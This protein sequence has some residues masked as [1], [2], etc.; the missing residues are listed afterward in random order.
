MTQRGFQCNTVTPTLSSHFPQLP[1]AHCQQLSQASKRRVHHNGQA[2]GRPCQEPLTRIQT[3]RGVEEVV[4]HVVTLVVWR[5]IKLSLQITVVK[6]DSIMHLVRSN[7]HYT[8]ICTVTLTY[9]W[10]MSN[11]NDLISPPFFSRLCNL[12][13]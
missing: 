5:V 10:S 11:N 2:I 9:L 4:E 13:K 3:T 1:D 12:H 8:H 7:N 6:F